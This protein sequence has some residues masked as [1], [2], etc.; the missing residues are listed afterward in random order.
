[1]TIKT[2]L[3]QHIRESYKLVREYQEIL[4]LSDNPKEQARSRRTIEEQQALIEGYLGEYVLLCRSLNL[5]MPEDV[6]LIA[7]SFL[8]QPQPSLG[9]ASVLHKEAVSLD[10]DLHDH[11][12]VSQTHREAPKKPDRIQEQ[13]T[14]FSLEELKDVPKRYLWGQFTMLLLFLVSII[15]GVVGVFDVL[16]CPRRLVLTILILLGGAAILYLSFLTRYRN[17]VVVTC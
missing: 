10:V 4:R 8:S 17:R 3:E 15:E 5:T 2:D 7:S 1:M 12:S 6:T 16:P 14:S 13:S 11:T 9:D